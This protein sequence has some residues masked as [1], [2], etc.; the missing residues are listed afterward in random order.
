MVA[1]REYKPLNTIPTS[2]AITSVAQPWDFLGAQQQIQAWGSALNANAVAEQNRIEAEQKQLELERQEKFKA[3]LEKDILAGAKPSEIKMSE[4]HKKVGDMEGYLKASKAEAQQEAASRSRRTKEL[5]DIYALEKMAPGA[6]Q[7]LANEMSYGVL[8]APAPKIEKPK[9]PKAVSPDVWVD[10]NTG[11]EVIV[12]TKDPRETNLFFSLGYIP[13]KKMDE[14]KYY[15]LKEK[16]ETP[17][18]V[19]GDPNAKSGLSSIYEGISGLLKGG[20][21]KG[22]EMAQQGGKKKVYAVPR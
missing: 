5:K 15:E 8:R 10:T 13:K 9:E 18:T 22:R 2:T 16:R 19:P 17:V 6:G 12:N 20:Y 4:I 14:S 11:E 3:E 1:Y 7:A 21:D